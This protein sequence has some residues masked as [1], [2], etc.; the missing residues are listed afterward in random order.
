M[1]NGRLSVQALTAWA[2][3]NGVKLDGVEIEERAIGA[4]SDP[5][6]AIVAQQDLVEEETGPLI[7]VPDHLVLSSERVLSEAQHHADL[8]ELLDAASGLAEV[9]G[10]T[11]SS[12]AHRVSRR[13]L[14]RVLHTDVPG[15]DLALSCVAAVHDSLRRGREN[16]HHRCLGRV[17]LFYDDALLLR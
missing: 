3:V 11:P 6:Y 9:N 4:S 10:P 8:K 16:R 15:C 7:T 12:I 1:A 5:G 13:L 14:T 17:L 2:D